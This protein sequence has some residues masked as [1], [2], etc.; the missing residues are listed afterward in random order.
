MLGLDN[1]FQTSSSSSELT[2]TNWKAFP[3]YFLFRSRK[4]GTESRHGGHQV[5]QKSSST[6]L[7]R[8]D[9][10]EIF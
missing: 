2:P 10:F 1:V 7:P 8:T 5:P 4:M 6:I 3:A 9:A